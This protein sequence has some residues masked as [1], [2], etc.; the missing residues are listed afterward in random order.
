MKQFENKVA[1]VTGAASGIGQA[2]AKAFLEKG[3]SVI[4]ADYSPIEIPNKREPI[5]FKLCDVSKEEE[6]QNLIQFGIESF[7]RIDVAVHCAGIA[8]TISQKTHMYPKEDFEKQIQVNLMGTWY[9]LKHLISH[10]LT[11][12]GGNITCISSAAGLIGQAENIPYAASKH[13]INGM[14]KTAAIEYAT[15][16]IRVNAICPTAIETPMIMQG[17]RKL[18]DNPQ[19]LEQAIQFQRM[20]RMGQAHEIAD[21]ALWLCSEQSSFVTGICMPADGGALA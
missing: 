6:I 19:A 16:N 12:G 15:Q 20:K 8:G 1:L 7:G 21:I 17:R 13:A 18:A 4:L 11:R 14:V 2:T 3:A 9:L 10:F 5:V